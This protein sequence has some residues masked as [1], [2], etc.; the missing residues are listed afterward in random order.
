MPKNIP[1][2]GKSLEFIPS[3]KLH[4]PEHYLYAQ[5]LE[6]E[7]VEDCA[8]RRKEFKRL[9]VARFVEEEM[10]L[11]EVDQKD[12][13]AFMKPGDKSL[14]LKRSQ[15]LVELTVRYLDEGTAITEAQ[16]KAMAEL[17]NQ[18]SPLRVAEMDEAYFNNPDLVQ[19]DLEAWAI[20]VGKALEDLNT[21]DIK[22]KNSF[23]ASNGEPGI[24]G[25]TYLRRAMKALGTKGHKE[26]LDRLKKTA[27]IELKKEYPEMDEAYFADPEKVK[28]DLEAWASSVKKEVEDLSTSDTRSEEGFTTSNGEPGIRGFTYLNRAMKALGIEGKKETLDRLKKTA[29]IELK[30]EYPK[31]DKVYFSDRKKVEADLEAWASSVGKTVEELTTGDND[32]SSKK[33]F[34]ASNGEPGIRGFTYLY[35]AMKALGIKGGK[36]TLDRLKKTAG[37]ELKTEYPK[38][39]KVYFSDRKKVEADLEAWASSV[40]KAVEDL[41]TGDIKSKNSFIASNGEPGIRGFTYLYRAMKALGTKGKKE[42]LLRLKQIAGFIQN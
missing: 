15:A 17:L 26:T 16:R 34:T 18:E 19:A 30:T 41:T 6:T 29:G 35:R 5:F 21:G 27:G 39:D 3:E 12:L 8:E 38:M 11:P 13:E 22:S 10:D 32:V 9:L 24:R 37:I 40:G 4:Y 7:K 33:S 14:Q 1:Q 2:S 20:S 25:F 23:T 31:M 36:E 28:A 42:T